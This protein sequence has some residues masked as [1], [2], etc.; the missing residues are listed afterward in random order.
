VRPSHDCAVFAF[1]DTTISVGEVLRAAHFRGELQS[2]ASRVVWKMACES[3][4]TRLNLEPDDVTIDAMVTDFRY[5]NDLIAAEETEAWL[6]CRGLKADEFQAYFDRCHWWKIL[7]EKVA[8]GQIDASRAVPELFGVLETE[9]LMSGDLG[10]LAIGLSRRLM[11]SHDLESRPDAEKVTEERRRF[12]EHADL[13]PSGLDGWLASLDRDRDWFEGMIEM[14]AAYRLKCDAILAPE[15]MS[16]ALAASRLLLARLEMESI[17][18]DTIDAAREAY[19]CVRDD[20]LSLE[21]VARE[22]RYPFKRLEFLAED[23][24]EDQRQALLCAAV[25]EILEPVAVEGL[26]H[27]RRVLRKT[28]PTLDEASV[29]SRI[30]Q[31]VLETHFSGSGAGDVSWFIR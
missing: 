4:A 23:L 26:V 1:R 5:E 31:R 3:E 30:E 14:E 27:L 18:F 13:E 21:E 8:P 29:R 12:F 20:G 10:P 25:G 9:L 2:C 17:E 28:E 6:E 15:P 11:A 16:R 24:P 7:K 19:L 22:S